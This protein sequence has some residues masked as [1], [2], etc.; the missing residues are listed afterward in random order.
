[1]ASRGG[2]YGGGKN[3]KICEQ[4]KSNPMVSWDGVKQHASGAAPK[5]KHKITNPGF[6]PK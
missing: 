1:M 4:R 2:N 6:G 3:S 5:P